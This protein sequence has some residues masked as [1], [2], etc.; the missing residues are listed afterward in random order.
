[1]ASTYN[2]QFHEVESLINP[3]IYRRSIGALQYVCITRPDLAFAVNKL[4]QFWFA[5]TII[6]WTT[7]K[8]VLRYIKVTLH[9]GLFITHSISSQ[10]QGFCDVDWAGN[11]DEKRSMGGF[12]VYMGWNLIPWS[13]KK[14]LTVARSSIE[15][16]YRSVA[17]TTTEIIWLRSFFQEFKQSINHSHDHLVWQHRSFISN[18]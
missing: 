9:Q 17:N 3:K 16:E 5:P 1:M 18:N 15:A 11:Q 14:Q 4:Y 7:Y 13:A 8:Y 6:N 12:A 10:L 2:L